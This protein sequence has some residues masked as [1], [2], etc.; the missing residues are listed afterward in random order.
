M[1]LFGNTK[2]AF[3]RRKGKPA[4]AHIEGEYFDVWYHNASDVVKAIEGKATLIRQQSLSLFVPPSAHRDFDK[5]YPR[6]LHWLEKLDA[7]CTLR[8]PFRNWGDYLILTLEKPQ[9]SGE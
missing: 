8:W 6:L 1:F 7:A 9:L 2:I 5:K 3:R 4:R